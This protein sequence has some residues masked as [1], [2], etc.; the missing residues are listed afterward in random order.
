MVLFLIMRIGGKSNIFRKVIF[1]CKHSGKFMFIDNDLAI[2][3]VIGIHKN[4]LSTKYVLTRIV[5]DDIYLNRYILQPKLLTEGE[6][7]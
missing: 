4:T 7:R 5:I 3:R 2:F 6:P 1:M